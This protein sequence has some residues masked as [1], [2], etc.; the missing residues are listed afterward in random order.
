MQYISNVIIKFLLVRLNYNFIRRY[1]LCWN[2]I[3]A[4]SKIY[5]IYIETSD[6]LL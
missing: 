5:E 6:L 4:K 3:N 2:Y 1:I